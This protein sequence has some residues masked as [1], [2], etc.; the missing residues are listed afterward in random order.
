MACE[1]E[2]D[3]L[4][5][6]KHNLTEANDAWWEAT[7]DMT[8]STL[9]VIGATLAEGMSLG[10]ATM[11]FGSAVINEIRSAAK[12]D[13]ANEDYDLAEDLYNDAL[14]AYCNCLDL[15]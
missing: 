7:G 11:V 4:E 8:V 3:A 2:N 1:I 10:L 5:N 15:N 12:M 6:A 9:G 14:T 13:D